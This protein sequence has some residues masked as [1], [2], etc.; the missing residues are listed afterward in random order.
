VK[1]EMNEK[2]EDH[3]QYEL[4]KIR[5]KKMR[6]MLDAQKSQQANQ[7]RA[8]SFYEK[9]DFILRAV[10]H[11]SAYSHLEKL[12]K[13]EPAVYQRIFNEL[14]SPDVFQSLDYLISVIKQQGGVPRQIPLDA[15]IYL[16]RK[17]KGIKMSIKVKQGDGEVMDL[18]SYL[19]KK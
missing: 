10:L 17:V 11:P 16:E 18:G 14:I 3:E 12:K 9:V 7:E 8:G 5:L 15:I 19:T 13:E 1:D 2:N 4:D 6:D